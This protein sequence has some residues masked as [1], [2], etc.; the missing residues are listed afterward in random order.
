MRLGDG[1]GGEEARVMPL[2]NIPDIREKSAV[3]ESGDVGYNGR[4]WGAGRRYSP[5]IL[6]ISTRDACTDITILDCR[7]IRAEAEAGWA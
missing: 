6:E 4:G 7:Y 5:E 1:G 2:R 3:G